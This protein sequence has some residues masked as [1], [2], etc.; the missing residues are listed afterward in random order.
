MNKNILSTVAVVALIAAAVAWLTRTGPEGPGPTIAPAEI[1]PAE[2]AQRRG[3]VVDEIVFTQES[4]VGKITEL[5]ESGSHHVFAQGITNATV[6]RR[7]RDSGRAAYNFSYGSSAELSI[8][9]AGP[10]FKDGRINPFHVPA[11]REALNNLIDRRH[12]AEELYG[13]LAVPR[14]LPL[15]T[16]FPDYARLADVARAIEMRYQHDPEGAKRRIAEEMEKLG[17]RLEGGRWMHEGAPVRMTV[18]IRTED[19]RKRVGDYVANLLQDAGFQTERMY[20]TAE[21]ASRIWIVGDPHAGQWN[22]YTGAWISLS[23][24]RDLAGNLSYYYTPRGRPEPL[25]QAYKPDP[26]L[27]EIADRL[28]RRDYRTWDERQALMARG[29]DL[30][31]KDSVRIWLIDQLN[32]WPRARNV[33]LAVDLA[34]GI[35]GSALWPYTIRFRDR[36]GGRVVFGTPSLLTEPWNPVAGSNWIFD[37]MIIRALD[38]PPVIPDP[39]TGLFWPQRIKHAQVTVQRGMPVIRTHDWLA[40]DSAPEIR[41]PRDTWID[42]DAQAERFIT[43]GEKHPQGITARTRT[44]VRY[45]KGYLER[46]WHDGTQIS[47]ADMVL[48]WILTFER[49]DERSR[50]YDPS[51]VPTFDVFKRHFRGWRIVSREPLEIEVYSDQ[52]YPDAEW[53]V[54]ARAASVL[55]WH[56]LALGI[57]AERNG[58]LAFSSNKADRTSVD[59]M[60]LIAGPSLRILERQLNAARGQTFVPYEN[61]LRGLMREGE[62]ESRYAALAGWHAQR[63]HFWIGDGPFYLHS[64]H[65]VERSVVLR[66][67]TDFPDSADKWMRFTRPEIPDLE[68]DGPMVVAAGEPVEFDLHISFDGEPYPEAEIEAAQFLVF[69]GAGQLVVKGEAQRAEPG[70]W[71]I[72]LGARDLERLGAGS[73]SLEVAVTS[74]RVALP[75]FASHAFAT[76]PRERAAGSDAVPVSGDIAAAMTLRG[77]AARVAHE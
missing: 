22:V 44:R 50:L 76:V 47:L 12:I 6:F 16:V 63:R 46:R 60:S 72:A 54:A 27:D 25:W 33:D 39:F 52:I 67:Y 58:E 74:R 7:V 18:L 11:I 62:A 57:L 37:N 10:R 24:N 77:G 64:V 42:W 14:F 41:V 3:A 53:I 40:V 2:L 69:G 38:D 49:A 15:T 1:S 23:I 9:P 4:D 61:V 66:R 35:S 13:G 73:N 17:A 36:I 59:W 68:L 55:P 70:R 32:V 45:E 26:E 65:P 75:A 28:Q 34:G 43:A 21:E 5:I 48:P 29:L 56:T 51:Y 19:E 31:M 20:R 30:A 8:N 71:R